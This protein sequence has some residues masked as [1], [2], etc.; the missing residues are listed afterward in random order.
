METAQFVDAE[1]PL[2]MRSTP[3][4][5]EEKDASLPQT[6]EREKGW[7]MNE[8]TRVVP[9]QIENAT[10]DDEARAEAKAQT[11]ISLKAAIPDVS[12]PMT[13]ESKVDYT[14]QP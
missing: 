9:P 5:V 13:L 4:K 7:I 3:E 12:A 1:T 10:I 8:V 2:D 6:P 14:A 11:V